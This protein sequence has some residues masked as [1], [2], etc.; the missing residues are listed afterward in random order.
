MI[1]I[2]KPWLRDK[3]S[4]PRNG[5]IFFRLWVLNQF[6]RNGGVIYKAQCLL[7]RYLK[8][9]KN[10][11]HVILTS[12]NEDSF[13][14]KFSFEN[15]FPIIS[16]HSGKKKKEQQLRRHENRGGLCTLQADSVKGCNDF[17]ESSPSVWFCDSSLCLALWKNVERSKY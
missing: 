1:Q 17:S 3:T 15:N 16:S 10:Y 11:C 7:I 6:S 14:I 4:Q 12:W 9:I 5:R 2:R 8:D 13:G